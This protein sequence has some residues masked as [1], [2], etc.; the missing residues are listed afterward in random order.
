MIA[1]LEVPRGFLIKPLELGA[2][3][4][5]LDATGFR[6]IQKEIPECAHGQ[7]SGDQKSRRG[8]TQMHVYRKIKSGQSV[9]AESHVEL[10]SRRDYNH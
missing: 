4:V 2:Q 1:Q 9:L 10:V 8:S 6:N 7:V 3:Y 5:Y